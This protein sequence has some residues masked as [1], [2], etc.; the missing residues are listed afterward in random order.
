MTETL[1]S[2]FWCLPPP[3]GFFFFFFFFL[4]V[5]VVLCYL[6]VTEKMYYTL[7]RKNIHDTYNQMH[8]KTRRN[9]DA[10]TMHLLIV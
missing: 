2:P 6:A 3:N 10:C 5:V 7:D 4:V 9:L 8:E 1:K